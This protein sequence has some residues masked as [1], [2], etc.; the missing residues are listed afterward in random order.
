[1]PD[2]PQFT[3]KMHPD[4]LAE[5]DTVYQEKVQD[6]DARFL[7]VWKDIAAMTN[8]QM[9]DWN[10]KP[11]P[12]QAQTGKN[13]YDSS[14]LQAS[15]ILA[16]GVQGSGFGRNA[17]WFALDAESAE[18]SGKD[19]VK[20]YLQ[21]AADVRYR[22]FGRS[23]FYDIG[24]IAVKTCADFGTVAVIAESDMEH[25]RQV[26]T[27]LHIK[28]YV[29]LEDQFHQVDT[30]MYN[31][32]I[33]A[34]EAAKR[35]GKVNL[36]D[37]IKQHLD[38]KKAATDL[39]KFRTYIFPVDKWGLE[40]SDM[41]RL[42]KG[43]PYATV[44]VSEADPKKPVAE[45]GY[46]R[47]RFFVWRWSLSA[48]GTELGVDCPGLTTIGD[49]KQANALRRDYTRAA[50]LTA[51]PPIKAT[52]GMRGRIRMTPGGEN[53]VKP[54]DD[55]VPMQ[56]AGNLQSQL[57]DLQD[58]RKSINAGYMVDIFLILSQNVERQKTATEVTGLQGEKA[59]L[60]GAF[61]GRLQYEFLEPIIEDGF[62]DDMDMSLLPPAPESAQGKHIKIDMI[63]PLA[64]LQKRAVTIDPL[65]EYIS[66]VAGLQQFDQRAMD[67]VD[68]NAFLQLL[69]DAKGISKK[70]ARNA[71]QISQI[72]KAKAKL[73]AQ[74]QAQ[75]QQAQQT[76]TQADAYNKMRTAPEAG[77]PMAQQV[78]K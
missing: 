27:V 34:T 19:D 26:Y 15:N 52:E 57:L 54:G 38:N 25:L 41:K 45:D 66:T 74:Q 65:N 10:D 73:I 3:P 7:T 35:F 59:V 68:I 51:Q 64:M 78:Q 69:A 76:Q 48:D 24:R 30:L 1:M 61:Y 22:Q 36:P 4:D 16:N 67:S 72:Q 40:K 9:N 43:K 32:W 5:I 39:F 12:S 14:M 58:L 55:M 62:Q 29:I 53:F 47:K 46:S 13:I 18:L 17:R 60:M 70:V 23:N 71:Y 21:E 28:R 37:T 44:T 49:G 8:P 20:Q 63:S 2:I 42:A 75:E 33:T 11:T 6:R 50:A 31:F 77:S 56:V